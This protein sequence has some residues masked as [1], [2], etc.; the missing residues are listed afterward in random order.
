[1]RRKSVTYLNQLRKDVS[2]VVDEIIETG[3]D[4]HAAAED[5]IGLQVHDLVTNDETWK[6]QYNDLNQAHLKMAKLLKQFRNARES[7]LEF[8]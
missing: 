2:Q 1:M 6:A 7:Y 3:F 4:I 5:L 8:F